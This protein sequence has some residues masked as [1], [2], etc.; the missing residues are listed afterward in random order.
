[1]QHTVWICALHEKS[2][3]TGFFLVRIFLYLDWK[4]ENIDQKNSVFGHFSRS[5]GLQKCRMFLVAIKISRF[6]VSACFLPNITIVDEWTFSKNGKYNIC[7]KEGILKK[8]VWLLLSFSNMFKRYRVFAF[9][10]NKTENP[11]VFYKD[12]FSSWLKMYLEVRSLVIKGLLLLRKFF[13]FVFAF[14]Y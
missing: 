7:N 6:S 9:Y 12:L 11:L 4:R 5:F 8:W 2:P 3:N 13:A 10:N 14:F 1:M